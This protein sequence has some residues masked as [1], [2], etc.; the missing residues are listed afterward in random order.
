M[1]G[2]QGPLTFVRLSF[3]MRFSLTESGVGGETRKGLQ[4]G[5]GS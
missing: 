2:M 4:R 5:S 3:I 1:E